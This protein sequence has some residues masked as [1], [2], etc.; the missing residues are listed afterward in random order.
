MGT[1][2]AWSASA[3]ASS[4]APVQHFT[5]SH[6]SLRSADAYTTVLHM[7]GHGPNIGS[8]QELGVTSSG[9]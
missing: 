8:L 9:A 3:I 4:D 7:L 1:V 2:T 6:C 5:F